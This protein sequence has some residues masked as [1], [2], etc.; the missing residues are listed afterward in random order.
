METLDYS[1][2]YR[3]QDRVLKIFFGADTN[4]YLTG[5]TCL[6]RFFFEKRYSADLDLLSNENNLFREDVRILLDALAANGCI[7]EVMIDTRDFVRLMAESKLKVDLVND[8][9]YRFGKSARAPEGIVLDN[10]Q[11]IAANKVCAVLGRDEPKDVFDLY[12]LFCNARMDWGAVLAASAK[13]C[14]LDREVLEYR[15]NSFPLD[16]VDLLPVL[17]HSFAADCKK[18]YGRMVKAVC[19]R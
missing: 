7:Y 5:G 18:G 3:I 10:I 8:R 12:T 2:L 13:K 6:N 14:A 4:F 19:A 16:L 15:L 11:N 1:A 9:V 17:D